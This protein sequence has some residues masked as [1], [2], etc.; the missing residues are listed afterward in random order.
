MPFR[1]PRLARALVVRLAGAAP[2]LAI[3]ASDGAADDEGLRQRRPPH[4]VIVEYAA[5]VVRPDPS[6]YF[7]QI[8][9]PDVLAFRI[10]IVAPGEVR[11]RPR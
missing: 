11:A 10:Q 8:V 2:F 4:R 3:S 5:Y 7:L 1:A 9:V 6:R